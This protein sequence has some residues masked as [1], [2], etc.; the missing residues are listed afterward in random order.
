MPRGY[1]L[2][3]D[4]F[5]R[6]RAEANNILLGVLEERLLVLPV[7]NQNESYIKVHPEFRAIFTSNPQEYSGGARRPGRFERPDGHDRMSIIS[8]AKPNSAI[9]AA[10]SGLPESKV[11]A[12]VELVRDYRAS[13]EYDQAPTLR[14][15]IMIARMVASQ[16][17][18]RPQPIRASCRYAS[19]FSARAPH[20]A[21]GR[22]MNASQQRKMLMSLIDHHCSRAERRAGLSG[23]PLGAKRWSRPQRTKRPSPQP[24]Q[25]H[26]AKE[27]KAMAD[28]HV[29]GF[30]EARRLP[31]GTLPQ[32]KGQ[33]CRQA[34]RPSSRVSIISEDCSSASSRCGPKSRQ[35]TAAA[36]VVLEKQI[37]EVERLIRGQGGPRAR[38][39]RAQQRRVA[40]LGNGSRTERQRPQRDDQCRILRR[41]RLNQG[42]NI[43]GGHASAKRPTTQTRMMRPKDDADAVDGSASAR[44]SRGSGISSAC[45][46]S[47]SRPAN[48][49][50]SRTGEFKVKGLGDK[51]HGVYGVSVRVGIGG[52]PHVE[53]FGNIRS[54][55]EGAGSR[56]RTRAADRCL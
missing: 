35:V 39:T 52:E 49:S 43:G 30:H 7:P 3:Y 12:I 21:A 47:W 11:S 41:R 23:P 9:T 2:I 10:R 36:S 16:N 37:A 33:N 55:K 38:P 28:G 14:A 1:T 6:S 20:S 48:N 31:I 53:R 5:T 40:Q 13:G 19:I 8:I 26:Q 56:R 27:H 4:E 29:K 44:C 17:H 24:V 18:A 45:S 50:I 25:S 42:H 46:A 22:R 54:T 15:G 34:R 51:A 32:P